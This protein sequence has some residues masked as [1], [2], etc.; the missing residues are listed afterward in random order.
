MKDLF[1]Y[2]KNDDGLFPLIKKLCFHTKWNSIQS[3]PDGRTEEW[4]GLWQNGYSLKNEYPYNE[5]PDR[6]DQRFTVKPEMRHYQ[7]LSEVT[8]SGN[9]RFFIEYKCPQ[10]YRRFSANLLNCN[11]SNFA[12]RAAAL[13]TYFLRHKWILLVKSA[14]LS[15]KQFPQLLAESGYLKKAVE[16]SLFWLMERITRWG[17]SYWQIECDNEHKSKKFMKR[18]IQHF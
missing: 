18:I 8:K 7:A 12:F 4:E 5:F 3:I 2:L 11:W 15:S 17:I 9:Q 10:D 6:F 13:H 1:Q 16:S 14:W